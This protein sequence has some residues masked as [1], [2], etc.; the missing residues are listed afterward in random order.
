MDRKKG[1]EKEVP[2]VNKTKCKR[3]EKEGQ[4]KKKSRKNKDRKDMGIGNR[5]AGKKKGKQ[6]S[7]T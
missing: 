3:E 2:E 1:K 5:K 6:G 4:S 7:E